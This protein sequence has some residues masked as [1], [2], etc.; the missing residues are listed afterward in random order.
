MNAPIPP[1][2]KPRKYLSI[3]IFLDDL[4]TPYNTHCKLFVPS[5]RKPAVSVPHHITLAPTTLHTGP[6]HQA[7]RLVRVCLKEAGWG[8]GHCH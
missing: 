5:G 1:T 6:L 8:H 3:V 2:H 4:E 7:C